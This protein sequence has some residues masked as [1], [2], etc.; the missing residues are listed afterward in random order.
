MNLL[1]SF[2]LE[3]QLFVF[4]MNGFESAVAIERWKWTLTQRPS[5][6]CHIL[7]SSDWCVWGWPLL[8][9][10]HNNNRNYQMIKTKTVLEITYSR[11]ITLKIVG[12][13]F[14]YRLTATLNLCLIYF[15]I[16]WELFTSHTNR[17][18]AQEVW[19]KSDKD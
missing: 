11:Q 14:S 16:T 6:R 10:N 2:L 1:P 7:V 19:D 18:L 9:L 17:A 13:P 8:K 12:Y 3:D 15:K 5:R 4:K